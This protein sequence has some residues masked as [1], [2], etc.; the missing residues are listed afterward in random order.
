MEIID[1]IINLIGIGI[2]SLPWLPF[3][4]GGY[5]CY[6]NYKNSAKYF[7]D[8]NNYPKQSWEQDP[9]N[10]PEKLLARAVHFQEIQARKI[11]QEN[12][13]STSSSN[14]LDDK[15]TSSS[16]SLEDGFDKLDKADVFLKEK[17]EI[18]QISNIKQDFSIQEILE[19][20]LE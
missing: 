4:L 5:C 11:K 18:Q 3:I 15:S 1:L 6:R 19:K 12:D 17:N 8:Q 9:R 13:K 10:I 14:S 2:G 7:E 16:N 20:I